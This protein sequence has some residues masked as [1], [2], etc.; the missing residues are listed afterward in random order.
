MSSRLAF[1]ALLV[2]TPAFAVDVF[3]VNGDPVTVGEW[4]DAAGICW[5]NSCGFNS[6]QCTGILV[7]PDVVLTA[8]HCLDGADP[9]A[10][11]LNSSDLVDDRGEVVEVAEAIQYPSY[12]NAYDISVLVLDQ[13][14]VTPWRPLASGCVLDEYLL[15][16]ASATI[17][18]FGATNENG[19]QYSPAKQWADIPITDADGSE[20]SDGY[21][22]AVSPGG[23]MGAGGDGTDSCFGDSGGPLYLNTPYG[24]FVAGIVSRSYDWAY[25]PPCR[26]GGIYVRPDAVIDWIEEETGRDIP[27]TACPIEAKAGKAQKVTVTAT[28]SAATFTISG[29]P[30]HGHATVT[31]GGVVKYTADNDYIGA[32]QVVVVATGASGT[33]TLVV[34]VLVGEGGCGCSTPVGATPGWLAGALGLLLV[35][36]RRRA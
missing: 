34:P 10:V 31:D 25:D 22:N 14:A 7:A 3:I 32:D 27:E 23:E 21:V 2:A 35:G 9:S 17:V 19:S 11:V 15:D 18:G 24:P 6:V 20:T 1:L 4:P 33:E 13:P 28:D 29:E 30:L 26:D 36:R 8:G 12:W 16:G 5:G